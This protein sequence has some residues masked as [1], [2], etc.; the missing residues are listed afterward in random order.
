M[1]MMKADDM[2]IILSKN[3]DFINEKSIVE[4]YC[5]ETGHLV[6][7]LPKSHY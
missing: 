2:S 5:S 6:Y 4:Y 3:D 7:F 1:S